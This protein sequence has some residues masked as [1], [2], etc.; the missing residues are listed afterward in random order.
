M[1]RDLILVFLKGDAV[2]IKARLR[3]L[4]ASTSRFRRFFILAAVPP[5]GSDLY[6]G[7]FYT[8]NKDIFA[9]DCAYDQ[10]RGALNA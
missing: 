3:C 5:L 9:E 2:K 6:N 7:L 8:Q 4:H 1:P 10:L